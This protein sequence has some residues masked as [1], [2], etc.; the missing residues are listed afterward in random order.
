MQQLWL[1]NSSKDSSPL[2]L[3]KVIRSYTCIGFRFGALLCVCMMQLLTCS[4]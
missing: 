4:E 2:G 3:N 1:G